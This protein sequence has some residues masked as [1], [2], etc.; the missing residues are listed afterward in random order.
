MLNTVALQIRLSI[1]TC[2]PRNCL[3]RSAN[4]PT[5]LYILPSIIS[6]VINLSQIIS[7]STGPIFTIFSP[8]E[9]YLRKFSRSGPLF[10]PLRTLQWQPILGKICEIT[11]IEHAGISQRIWLSQFGFRS[12]KGH[13]VCYIL[14]NFDEYR[15]TNPKDHE[16]SFCTFWD[17]TAKIDMLYQISQQILDRTSPTFQH[18]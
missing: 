10:I 4:L 5:G 2:R 1:R 13:N 7:G 6:S 8:N 16:G 9:R 18:W 14:C 3:A 15:S 12:D 11:F 17:E